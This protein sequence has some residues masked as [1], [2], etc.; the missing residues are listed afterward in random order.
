MKKPN[1]FEFA[2]KELSQDA[3]ICW[4]ASWA[5]KEYIESDRELHQLGTYFLEKMF[6]KKILN[7][8]KYFLY[9]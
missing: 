5:K 1:I 7:Y 8:P 6:Q 9:P 4:L 2:T 3:F